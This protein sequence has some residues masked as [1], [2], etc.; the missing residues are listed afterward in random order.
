MNI[1]TLFIIAP[2]LVTLVAI[3]ILWL[4]IRGIA[5]SKGHKISISD[6]G[7]FS[8]VLR[9]FKEVIRNESDQKTRSSFQ[10]MLRWYYIAI[11]MFF[12]SIALIVV[13]FHK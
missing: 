3:N 11:A 13:F 1:S 9:S 10:A 5:V 8:G 4:V 6:R 7:L 2:L 12:A